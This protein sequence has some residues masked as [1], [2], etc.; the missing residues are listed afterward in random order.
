VD[1]I[2]D[3]V[4]VRPTVA[5]SDKLLFRLVDH[6][7]IDG[8]AVNGTARAV[9][10]LADGALKYLQTGFTQSYVLMMIIGAVVVI[11]YIVR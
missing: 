10:A 11:G 7:L 1:E 6:T 5:I 4:I 3:W 8:A 2:Y 9:R